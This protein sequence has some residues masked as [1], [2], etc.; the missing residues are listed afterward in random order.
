MCI[1]GSDGR[2]ALQPIMQHNGYKVVSSDASA[3]IEQ[4]CDKQ[5][6][7]FDLKCVLQERNPTEKEWRPLA[8]RK[9]H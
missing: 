4:Q 7:S 6:N 8:A 3:L 1:N 9:Y 2:S 5:L